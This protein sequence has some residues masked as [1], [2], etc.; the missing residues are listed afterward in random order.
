MLRHA[1]AEFNYS[2]AS[3]LAWIAVA[4][5]SSWWPF[6]EA[7]SL[8]A[9][10]TVLAMMALT[11]PLITPVQCFLL[12]NVERNERRQRLWGMLPVAP[13]TIAGARLLRAAYLPLVAV[14]LGIL[15]VALAVVFTGPDVLERLNGA[16][17]LGVLVLAGFALGVFVTLLYD[18]GGMVF[19]QATSAF[20]VAAGFMLNAF[21]PAFTQ[22]A[23]Q[24]TSF[25]Q[26]AAGL[27]SM[28]G[29]CVLL[30]VGDVL[31]YRARRR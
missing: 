21:V 13:A 4:I 12:L 28:L 31:V 15:L 5:V 2:L 22:L 6:I 27:L 20:L 17:A 1:G 14:V 10:P 24:V 16:W 25:A 26:T 7:G 18:V 30:V 23:T 9:T 11:V 19:A 8:S 29:L 3:I